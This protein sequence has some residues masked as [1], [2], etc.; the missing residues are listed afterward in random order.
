MKA[1]RWIGVAS[2]VYFLALV[3]AAWSSL[4]RGSWALMVGLLLGAGA[5]VAWL[6]YT[7]IPSL[8]VILLVAV[9]VRLVW[10]AVPPVLSDDSYRY[11]WD[12]QVVAVGEN[13]YEFKPSDPEMEAFQGAPLYGLL[14][15]NE[16]YSVYPPVSQALFAVSWWGGGGDF[17]G[18]FRV[19]NVLV[20]LLEL[21]ALLLLARMVS[22]ET[23]LLYAW[24]PLVVV[25]GAG[26]GHTDVLLALPVVLAVL[27][28]R[29][30]RWSAGAVMLAVAAHIKIWPLLVLPAFLRR[31]RAVAVGILA[32]SLLAIPFAAPW[33]IAHVRQ[34]LDLYVRYFEFNAGPY[35]ALKGLFTAWTGEDWSKQL[36]P[37]LRWVFLAGLAGLWW[38]AWRSR[39]PDLADVLFWIAGLYLVTA[40]TVHPWYLY[41]VLLLAALRDRPG[42]AWQWLGL[43]SLGTYLLYAEGPYWAF[44][45]LGWGGFGVIGLVVAWAPVMRYSLVHRARWK[46]D[47]LECHLARGG[48]SLLDVGG[49]EGFVA[50][51]IGNVTGR[52]VTVLEVE[53]PLRQPQTLRP[54]E[55][56]GPTAGPATVSFDT[57]D[58]FKMPYGNESFSA[59]FA[60]FSLHHAADPIAV[61]REMRR[62]TSGEIIVVESVIDGAFSRIAL[63]VL[64]PIVNWMRRPSRGPTTAPVGVSAAPQFAA[65]AQWRERFASVGLDVTAESIRYNLLHR[66]HLFR[67]IKAHSES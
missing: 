40:T 17:A 46:A 29:R 32:G 45:W 51:E 53:G 43:L 14:N 49:A 61:L 66:K 57:Y 55:P 1:P 60:V 31:P 15:S 2:V 42:W 27:C 33:V 30:S 3:W 52:Q 34:S 12:G 13:P 54:E 5:V 11:A 18:F 63:T 21:A 59:S 25:V 44:V 20:L 35:Y 38:T 19:W 50:M 36:G 8:R 65:P 39:K 41:P 56:T 22:P 6:R 58:G 7:A 48:G 28:A 64:D 47:W 16:F 4:D 37:A 10:L 9:A 26:Q 67:L 24:H 23:I 62:V